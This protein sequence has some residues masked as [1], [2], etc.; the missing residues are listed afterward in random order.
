MQIKL[1]SQRGSVSV[2]SGRDTG[3]LILTTTLEGGGPC[4]RG[5]KSRLRRLSDFLSHRAGEWW[6][7]LLCALLPQRSRTEGG[8][9]TQ[10]RQ[11]GL[12]QLER[13]GHALCWA[14]Q[15]ERIW[16]SQ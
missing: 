8:R 1:E 7:A 12:R 5:G 9:E 13:G 10:L 2:H 15:P 3:H 11:A 16:D 4:L 14:L 6:G